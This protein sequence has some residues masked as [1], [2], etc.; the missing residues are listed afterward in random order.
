MKNSP[1]PGAPIVACVWACL[2]PAIF[3]VAEA[4]P[5][6]VILMM[7]DDLGYQDLSCYGSKRNRTPVLDQLARDGIRLTSFYAGS[8]VCTPSRMA[9]LTGAYPV[10]VGWQGGVVGYG[11]KTVN[12]LAPEALTMAEVFKAAGYRTGLYGKWHL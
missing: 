10:R 3:A 1:S 7:A 2:V 4:A 8:T 11:I 5:P 9:L 6:N 12:G